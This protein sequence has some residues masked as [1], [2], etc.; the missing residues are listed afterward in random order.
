MTHMNEKITWKTVLSNE[1]KKSYFQLI[2]DFVKKERK[3]GKIIYPSQRDIFNALKLTPYEAVKV[4]IL[5][6]DPYYKPHQAHGLAFSVRHGVIPP[7]SLQNIFKELYLDVKVP[8]STQGN[9]EK[10]AMQGVLLLNTILT[11][12]AGKPQSHA[13]IGWQ[14]FTDR[15]IA[16]LNSHPKRI[17]FILWGTYAQQKANLITNIHHK[18]LKASHP[19]PLSA[20]RGFFGCRHFSKTNTY[21]RTV[22]QLEIN[23][24]L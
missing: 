22:K 3:I 18:I 13:N 9:L 11:V 7:P 8:I 15:I 10:W 6:Q 14:R 19:S 2:L 4:V 21:L 23:W 24:A 5:G 12:E 1:K 16:S 20:N 17:V